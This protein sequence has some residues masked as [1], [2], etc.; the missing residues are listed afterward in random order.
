MN[1]Q[2]QL[3]LAWVMYANDNQDKL[4]I[5]SDYSA[6]F[7][8]TPSWVGPGWMD[9][10]AASI[11][12]NTQFL[13]DDQYSLL[14]RYLGRNF[15]VFACPASRYV[16]PT[17]S[18]LGWSQRVRSCVM[19]GALGDGDKNGLGSPG[20]TRWVAKKMGQLH[21]P[22]PSDSWVF[23]DEHPDSIDDGIMY[24]DYY[25]AKTGTGQFTE[26]PGSQHAGKC[27]MSFADG[28][29]EIHKWM[30]GKATAP[31]KYSPQRNILTQNDPD[32]RWLASHT[33]AP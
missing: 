22:G 25:Y 15:N 17:Q 14:G 4:A 10:S 7:N 24:V 11:N 20:W 33:P 28:H 26:L 30:G 13:V 19:N 2:K 3:A 8:G 9:W 23:S 31:V 18:A 1:S 32:L 6:S 12:T 27:G 29:A 16:S 5:N 21:N